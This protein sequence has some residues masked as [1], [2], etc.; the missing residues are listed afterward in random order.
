MHDGL[1]T[2]EHDGSVGDDTHHVSRQSTVQSCNTLLLEDQLEGLLKSSVLDGLVSNGDLAKSCP[3]HLVG[4]CDSRSNEFGCPSCSK[5][6]S[7]FLDILSAHNVS[8]G[9]VVQLAPLG[10]GRLELFVDH[11][12]NRTLGDAQVGSAQSSVHSTDAL[13]PDDLDHAIK[14]VLVL[15]DTFHLKLHPGLDQPDRVGRGGRNNSS[16]RCRRKVDKCRL[17]A[18]V[19]VSVELFAVSICREVDSP[20]RIMMSGYSC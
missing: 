2:E 15:S 17:L 1:V 9:R 6:V 7:P 5:E 16:S 19:K 10:Q 4:I 13:G 8:L 11:P 20:T 3:E 12:L 18:S 14:A